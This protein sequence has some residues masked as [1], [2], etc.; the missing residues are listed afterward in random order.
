MPFVACHLLW[1]SAAAYADWAC[2][3]PMTE[4]EFEKYCRGTLPAVNSE[5][6]WGTT[7]IAINPYSLV[8]AG[9]SNETIQDNYNVTAGNAMYQSTYS[10]IN[11]PVRVGVFAA[12]SSNTGR[13]TSGCS[14]WGI[15]ELS[16]NLHELCVSLDNST[17]RSFTGLHGDG[18]IGNT[19]NCDVNLWPGAN[20]VGTIR[21]GGGW[22]SPNYRLMVSD[23]S[24]ISNTD[25]WN[26]WLG[27]R[28]VR[29]L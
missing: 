20:A 21:R 15:M 24:L 23:R 29:G 7:S 19:G 13:V 17:G 9:Q 12:H 27:F 4:L 14:Y 18:Y 26:N 6:A 1:P 16:G 28:A 25:A 10:T 3:R 8:N 11:G 22:D 2:L 5:Y